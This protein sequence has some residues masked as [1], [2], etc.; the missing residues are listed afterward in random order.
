[1]P[2]GNDASELAALTPRGARLMSSLQRSVKGTLNK[3]IDET[4]HRGRS[5]ARTPE[6]MI[7]DEALHFLVEGEFRLD[8]FLR[9]SVLP[10]T[11]LPPSLKK[12]MRRK[13]RKTQMQAQEV[14]CGRCGQY[15][16]FGSE[17]WIHGKPYC[18]KCAFNELAKRNAVAKAYP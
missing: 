16:P 1:V 3:L 7:V 6:S 17:T 10:N 11:P 18:S 2:S 9:Y 13:C 5:G 15:V 4:V 8:K 12:H 14:R